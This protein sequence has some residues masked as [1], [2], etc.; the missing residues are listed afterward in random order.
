MVTRTLTVQSNPTGIEISVSHSG[1]GYFRQTPF[2]VVVDDGVVVTLIAPRVKGEPVGTT[3]LAWY[4]KEWKSDGTSYGSDAKNTVTMDADYTRKAYYEQQKYFPTRN[5][6]RR[7]DKFEAKVDEEVYGLRTT[8][9]KP[10]MVEQQEVTTAQQTRIEQ[11]VGD[12]LNAQNLFGID[13]HHYRNFSQELWGLTR[14]FK[15]AALNKEASQKAIKW[16]TRGLSQTHLENI[17]KLFNI[18]LTF[19]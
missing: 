13:I 10:M 19:S 7:Q 5:P 18:T 16:K 14:I 9:L 1:Q 2:T 12:Y 6:Y 8:A 3:E 15:G 11:L 4:F 17:A